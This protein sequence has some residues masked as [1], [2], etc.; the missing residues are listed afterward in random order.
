MSMITGLFIGS[1]Y[2]WINLYHIIRKERLD[3]MDDEIPN[4]ERMDRA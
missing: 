3:E 1:S 4:P 2:A